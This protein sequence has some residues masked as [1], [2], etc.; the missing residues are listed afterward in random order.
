M[1]QKSDSVQRA[2]HRLLTSGRSDALK[3]Q[4]LAADFTIAESRCY[5]ISKACRS[6][7]ARQGCRVGP[8]ARQLPATRPRCSQPPALYLM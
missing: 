8:T 6:N 1:L 5:T 4:T 3:T 2:V 7:C